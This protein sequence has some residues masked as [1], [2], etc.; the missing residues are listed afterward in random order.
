MTH[1][2][3]QPFDLMAKLNAE[4]AKKMAVSREKNGHCLI[5]LPKRDAQQNYFAHNFGFQMIPIKKNHPRTEY[6]FKQ[7]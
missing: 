2:Y 7:I 1:E 5:W 4:Y 3:R 6:K